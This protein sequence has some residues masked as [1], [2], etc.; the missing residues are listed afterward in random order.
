M[1]LRGLSAMYGAAAAWRRR[2]FA[3]RPERRKRLARPVISV[4]NLRVGGSG[5]TPAVAHLVRL[6]VAHG[7]RPC[8]LSRGYARTSPG[9]GVT[10]VSDRTRVLADVAAAGDEPL[11]LAHALAGVPVLVSDSRYLAGR[12]AERRFDVTVHVLDDGFQHHE[13]ARDLDLLVAGEEDLDD[14]PLPAGR[15]RERLAAAAAAH[16]VLVPTSQAATADRVARALGVAAAF[17][18]TRTLG[19]PHTIVR[20]GPLGVAAGARVFGVAG[21]ARP[22]RFFADLSAAGW[23]VAGTL[24]FRD[25]HPYTNGDVARIEAAARSV[26]ASAILTTEKDAERLAVV[27]PGSLTIGAVPLTLTIEPADAFWRLLHERIARAAHAAP[28]GAA[29]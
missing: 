15:L 29:S 19:P 6:L 9:D 22:D 7:E 10:V 20:G 2:S 13:L 5:K 3:A 16:A 8:V 28:A 12:L 25:H 24:T 11:M 23:V 27:D 18:I 4:G 26:A 17:R 1:I 14:A 21:I